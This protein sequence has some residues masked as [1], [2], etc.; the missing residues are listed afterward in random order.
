VQTKRIPPGIEVRHSRYC[1][2]RTGEGLCNAGRKNGCRPT[3][4]PWVS[5]KG[6]KIRPVHGFPTIA[7]ARSWRIAALAQHQRSALRPPARQTLEEAGEEWL[8]G[9]R[10]GE[11]HSRGRKPYKPSV[12]RSYERALRLRVYPELGTQRISEVTLPGLQRFVNGMVAKKVDPSTIR[13][14]VNPLRAIYRHALS[15]GDVAVNPTMG[16]QLPGVEGMRDRI[17]T[18]AEAARLLAV[19][20][21]DDRALWAT[22]FYGGLRRGELRALACK[23]VDLKACTIRVERSWDDEG[24]FIEPKSRK[25]TRV[26]PIPNVLKTYLAEHI[27]RTGRRGDDLIF[28]KKR[29]E[30]FTP[31]TIRRHAEGAWAKANEAETLKAEEERRKPN[32]LTPIG[33]HEARHTYVSLMHAAGRSLEEVGDYVGHSSTYMTDRYRHLLP[34]SRTDAARALDAYLERST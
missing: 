13:N 16:L 23:S 26:V 2:T 28:G 1:P 27:A 12:L 33:L 24:G 8:E 18:P 25:G 10:N 3:Y 31:N 21:E 5:Q 17:A 11:I 20:P 15:I 6:Q 32:P 9:A 19:I 22:A 34:D 7:A 4:L 14:T 30:P 29:D